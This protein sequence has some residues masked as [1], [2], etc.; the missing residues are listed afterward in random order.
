[1]TEETSNYI[2][3]SSREYSLYVCSNRAIP[4]VTDG[5][6]DG[7]RKALWVLKPKTDKIKTISLA[8]EMIS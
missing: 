1:M 6:K 3:N 4:K 5:L 7:Q 8:G 2:L